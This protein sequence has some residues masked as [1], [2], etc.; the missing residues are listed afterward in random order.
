LILIFLLCIG[1]YLQFTLSVRLL[2]DVTM[3]ENWFLE[4]CMY[5]DPLELMEKQHTGIAG[6]GSVEF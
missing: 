2:E 1:Q 5:F 6:I 3:K 4:K